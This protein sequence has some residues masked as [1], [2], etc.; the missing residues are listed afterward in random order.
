[1]G[2]IHDAAHLR[3]FVL[4]Q[5]CTAVLGVH[6][7]RAGKVLLGSQVPYLIVLGGTDV[8]VMAED[9]SKC[10]VMQQALDK[11]AAVLAF[12]REMLSKMRQVVPRPLA[13]RPPIHLSACA[14]ALL[15]PLEPPIDFARSCMLSAWPRDSLRAADT[16][17]LWTAHDLHRTNV[18]HASSRA[19]ASAASLRFAEASPRLASWYPHCDEF[20]ES[21]SAV[22]L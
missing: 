7:F 6:A 16:G 14:Y 22:N 5:G 20:I 13:P 12:S 18:H 17:Q 1:M 4:Q 10:Q 19:R 15:T 8:N 2:E 9:A 21:T 3:S 11:S